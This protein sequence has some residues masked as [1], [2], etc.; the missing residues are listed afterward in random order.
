M[1]AHELHFE[2]KDKKRY[3]NTTQQI[4]TF[5]DVPGKFVF[6]VVFFAIFT[7]NCMPRNWR[8]CPR[9][10]R[11]LYLTVLFVFCVLEGKFKDIPSKL[12]KDHCE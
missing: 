3:R 8:I 6:F 10:R 5:F 7:I 11:N 4:D 9:G 1:T 2:K 12:Q